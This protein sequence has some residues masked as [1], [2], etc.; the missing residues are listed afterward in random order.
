LTSP[1]G[2]EGSI[3]WSGG[4]TP[5]TGSGDTFTT[6]WTTGSTGSRT[7]TASYC[8]DT[9]DETVTVLMD[10]DCTRAGDWED[11]FTIP[12]VCT[13]GG[14]DEDRWPATDPPFEDDCENT[15][16]V[17]CEG[18]PNAQFRD[19]YNDTLVGK[20]I[21]FPNAKNT[22][23]YRLTENGDRLERFEHVTGQYLKDGTTYDKGTK[24]KYDWQIWRYDCVTPYQMASVCRESTTWPSSPPWDPATG[25]SSNCE[26]G[27]P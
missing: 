11:D 13:P 20:C 16:L 22:W 25:S 14:P 7:V 9:E 1:A 3:S 12:T 5:A 2:Y 6:K 17:R 21:Y 15:L 18:T 8:N 19:Y 10:C 27:S 26:A 23:R 24:F 4:G